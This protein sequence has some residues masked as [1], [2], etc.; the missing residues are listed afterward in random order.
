MDINKYKIY[1][2]TVVRIGVSLVMLWFGLNQLFDSSSWIGYLPEFALNLPLEATTVVMFN[3]IFETI[4]GLALLLGLFTRFV[5]FILTLHLL[6]IISTLGYNEI[7]VRDFGLM[8]AMFS[9]FLH[10]PDKYCL[11]TKWK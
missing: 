1:A 10:G 4:F 6:G 8:L 9:V 11:E 2:P 7:A 5:A 3:G